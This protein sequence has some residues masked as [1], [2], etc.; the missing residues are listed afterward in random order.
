MPGE[1]P[2][3]RAIAP[4]RIG[5]VGARLLAALDESRACLEEAW[6]EGHAA[7]R[8]IAELRERLRDSR[9][10]LAVLGQFKRGKSTFVNALLGAP[11]L[12]IG[13]GS[14]HRDTDIHRVGAGAADPR[15]LSGR[16]SVRGVSSRRRAGRS[17]PIARTGHGRGQSG[18]PPP[19]RLR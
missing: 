6:P 2:Q 1:G 7:L 14:G 5:A 11:L 10:Q 4:D 18:E 13:G 8:S 12:P 9:L 17:G 15:H 19:H 16:P 3:A